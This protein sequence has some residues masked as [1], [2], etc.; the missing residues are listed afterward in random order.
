MR[1]ENEGNI[2]KIADKEQDSRTKRRTKA[3]NDAKAQDA[4]GGEE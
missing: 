2:T 1:K 3:K 4:A